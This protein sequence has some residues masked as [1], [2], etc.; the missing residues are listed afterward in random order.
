MNSCLCHLFSILYMHSLSAINCSSTFIHTMYR[1]IGCNSSHAFLIRLPPHQINIHPYFH[2]SIHSYL[3]TSYTMY[4][5]SFRSH[6][7]GFLKPSFPFFFF[8]FISLKT[9]Y[10]I[11]LHTTSTRETRIYDIPILIKNCKPPPTHI[12]IYILHITCASRDY[13]HWLHPLVTSNLNLRSLFFAAFFSSQKTVHTLIQ[14]FMH[15][16]SSFFPSSS[17]WSTLCTT[18]HTCNLQ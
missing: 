6:A 7:T 9:R 14:W 2:A 10:F 18:Y 1:T 16:S 5:V 3:S 8:I 4:N 13:Y 15:H 11:Y 12:Y 17:T